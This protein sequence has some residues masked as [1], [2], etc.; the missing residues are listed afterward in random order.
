[1]STVRTTPSR[2]PSSDRWS[3]SWKRIL[4]I[5]S[6]AI[7]TTWFTCSS[8]ERL[9]VSISDRAL[10]FPERALRAGGVQPVALGD[11]AFQLFEIGARP[12]LLEL[13]LPPKCAGFDPRDDKELE[14]RVGKTT[15]PMSALPGRFSI[16]PM[17][18]CSRTIAVRTSGAGSPR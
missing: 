2:S 7:V 14:I 10:R 15:V 8:I 5:L 12:L 6:R 13:P 18:R 16:L 4:P 17:A 3:R 1:M 11:L 9:E